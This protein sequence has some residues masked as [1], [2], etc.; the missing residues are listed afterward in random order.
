[1]GEMKWRETGVCRRNEVEPINSEVEKKVAKDVRRRR[2]RFVATSNT[3]A[4]HDIPTPVTRTRN[5]YRCPLP[6]QSPSRIFHIFA[7]LSC[8]PQT[9]GLPNCGRFYIAAK[10]M[11]EV[12]DSFKL[13][14]SI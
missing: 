8:I 10:M 4:Q 13:C 9:H 2:R 14:H 1:M 5:G 3:K 11:S 6:V 12:T 7:E